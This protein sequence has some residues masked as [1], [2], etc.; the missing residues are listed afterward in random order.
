MTVPSC[1][2][3]CSCDEEDDVS[4]LVTFAEEDLQCRDGRVAIEPPFLVIRRPESKRCSSPKWKE[5][6]VSIDSPSKPTRRRSLVL[7]RISVKA[8]DAVPFTSDE[9]CEEEP[10]HQ[11][12]ICQSSQESLP[13]NDANSDEP[14][15]SVEEQVDAERV[16]LRRRSQQIPPRPPLRKH[17]FILDDQVDRMLQRAQAKRSETLSPTSVVGSSP[18]HS[19]NCLKLIHT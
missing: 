19:A 16:S 17:S 15:L 2:E 3:F 18:Y 1:I 12:F 11:G 5:P 13:S 8:M 7:P 4:S 9:S 6:S 10:S 14:Q